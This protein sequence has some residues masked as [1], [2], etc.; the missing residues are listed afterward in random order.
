MLNG[1]TI[2]VV[3]PTRNEE[4]Q[5]QTV[6]ETMPDFVDRIIVI[7]DL[8]TDR[9]EQIVKK[10]IKEDRSKVTPL[11]HKNKVKPTKYNQAEI[12]VEKLNEKET[13]LFIKSEIVNKN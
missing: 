5:I 3:V 8:S 10:L 2:A 13:E 6:I 4:T 1:K 11:N 9:T 12:L 7:N